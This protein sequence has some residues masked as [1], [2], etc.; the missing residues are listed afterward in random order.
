MTWNLPCEE[1]KKSQERE[2]SL[3]EGNWGGGSLLVWYPI[4]KLPPQGHSSLDRLSSGMRMVPDLRRGGILGR[5]PLNW[6]LGTCEERWLALGLECFHLSVTAHGG[7]CLGSTPPRLR[8]VGSWLTWNR[9]GWEALLGV[10][11]RFWV[12]SSWHSFWEVQFWGNPEYWQG[13]FSTGHWR[14]RGCPPDGGCG[15]WTR[16]FEDEARIEKLENGH[17][18][19]VGEGR[20]GVVSMGCRCLGV[21]WDGIRKVAYLDLGSGLC[22]S[23]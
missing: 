20:T 11:G 17:E 16:V 3:G 19:K 12:T 13:R 2:R 8:R 5:G 15:T 10:R 22:E 6:V 1:G 21:L 7:G 14:S 23:A 4:L 9:S 18:A